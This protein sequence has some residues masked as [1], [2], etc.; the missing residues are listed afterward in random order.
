MSTVFYPAIL[1]PGQAGNWG[2][3]FPDFPGCIS[4]NDTLESASRSAIEALQGH[5]EVML[6]HGET[7]P[8][9]GPVNQVPDW[10]EKGDLIGSQRLL[11]PVEAVGESVRVNITLDRVLLSRIDRAAEE[12]GMTRSG[13]LAQAARDK[14]AKPAAGVRRSRKAA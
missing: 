6:E 3:V 9:P 14:M 2:V 7:L 10:L 5:I 1:L 4:A 13:F 8:A 12:A 11:V